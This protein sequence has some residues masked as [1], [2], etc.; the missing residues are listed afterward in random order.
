LILPSALRLTDKERDALHAFIQ[1]GGVV[2]A[3]G[4]FAL[5]PKWEANIT[6][7]DNFFTS[8]AWMKTP[9]PAFP[10]TPEWQTLPP[11]II[12][13]PTRLQDSEAFADEL[14][15]KVRQHAV[16]L[17]VTITSAKGFLTLIHQMPDQTLTI[18]CLAAEFDTDINHELD[19]MRYHRSRVNL[20]TKAEPIG[21]DDL[22]QLTTSAKVR[23]YSPLT[24]GREPKVS[25]QGDKVTITLP[26]K[27]AYAVIALT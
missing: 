8:D 21:T 20:I 5:G 27:C 4:P 24:P 22:I 11:G 12:W 14:L 19:A 7:P 3:T 23:A 16:T 6:A 15:A 18:H 17:P 26:E 10:G 1:D 2:L 13:N 9:F 25:R